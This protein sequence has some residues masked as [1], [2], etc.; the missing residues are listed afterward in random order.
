MEENVSYNPD[1]LDAL[2]AAI[3]KVTNPA[4]VSQ[5]EYV[6][7]GNSGPTPE[8]LSGLD[9]VLKTLKSEGRRILGF[10]RDRGGNWSIKLMAP[11]TS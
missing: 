7:A 11:R 1:I 3:E 6:M 5:H 4:V 8:H 2:N 10:K 9:E